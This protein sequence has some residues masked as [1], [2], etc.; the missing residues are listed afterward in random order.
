MTFRDISTASPSPVTSSRLNSR[1]RSHSAIRAN[2]VV[3]TVKLKLKIVAVSLLLTL[4]VACATSPTGRRQFMIVSEDQA[5]AS[6][7]T[8]YLQMLKPYADDGK[9]DNDPK[10][11]A[12]VHKITA[13]LIAQAVIMRPE[14]RDWEW[15]MKIL[16]DPETVNAWA[17]AGGKMALYTGL[18]EQIEPT[19]DELAQ[20][21]GHEISHALAKH[22]AEKMS[23]AM[24]TSLGIL[25][26]GIAS[27][28]RGATMAGAAVAAKLA[29]DL[30][31]SR[32]AEAEADQIGIELAAKAGYDPRAAATLWEK[33]G[34]LSESRPPQF[35]STHPAPENRQ[36][37]LT[38]LATEMMPYY[39]AKGERPIFDF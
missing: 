5:I 34:K 20:V 10:L 4:L 39:K 8:A 26:I 9:L 3:N 19:D 11:K 6:S 32:T 27:D 24:A 14:T 18:V 7:K 17:M 23:V 22:S 28:N 21:L 37:T 15:S 33:M 35:L 13:R 25:A 36:E 29:I 2:R 38:R 16:D 31:N 1:G 12:R 30:P